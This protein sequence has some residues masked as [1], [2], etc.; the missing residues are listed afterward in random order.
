MHTA[1]AVALTA[2]LAL[3][4][5]FVAFT[6]SVQVI[7]P[8]RQRRM[9]P[10][11]R[12][13]IEVV[14]HQRSGIQ[15][16]RD[17]G[18]PPGRYTSESNASTLRW[19]VRRFIVRTFASEMTYPWY[20]L[21]SGPTLEQG[22]LLENCL[23]PVLPRLTN[24]PAQSA[25]PL[26]NPERFR[27]LRPCCCAQSVMRSGATEELTR[28][29]VCPT[30]TLDTFYTTISSNKEKQNS[31]KSNLRKGR[32]TAHHLLNACDITGHEAP[33][34]VADFGDAFGIPV[35]YAIELASAGGRIRLLP[36]DCEH[37]WLRCSLGSI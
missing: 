6:E 14:D 24:D 4:T 27:R 34:L 15:T 23:A 12:E 30:Y 20:E 1:A 5:S 32:N 29:M 11:R 9:I 16:R 25:V 22:D 28:V 17:L 26:A 2:V 35:E 7:S 36:P 33:H 13:Q 8:L 3:P 21:V 31:T 19:R 10:P 37:L 18:L